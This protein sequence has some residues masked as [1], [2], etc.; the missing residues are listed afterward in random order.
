M[1]VLVR[2][3]E[4]ANCDSLPLRFGVHFDKDTIINLINPVFLREDVKNPKRSHYEAKIHINNKGL[5]NGHFVIEEDNPNPVLITVWTQRDADSEWKLSEVIRAL[6]KSGILTSNKLLEF[7]SL[8][9]QGKITQHADIVALLAENLSK[10]KLEKLNAIAATAVEDAARA[11]QERDTAIALLKE[12]RNEIEVKN[13]EIIELKEELELANSE[14]IKYQSEAEAAKANNQ[15]AALSPATLLLEVKEKQLYRGSVCTLLVMGD[16]SQR[17]M[18][19]S[20][21]DPN[22]SITEKAKTLIGKKVRTTCWNPVNEPEKW[23]KQGY[24][25]NIYETK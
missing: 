6:R 11:I 12:S 9:L 1:K 13:A 18:K 21:F 14:K 7:H 20:T 16:N 23:T 4:H 22:Y 2:Q 17:H 25:R 24:F 15:I 5:V 19:I 8:Y 3:R 10:E